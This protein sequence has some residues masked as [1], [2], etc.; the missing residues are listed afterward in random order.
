MEKLGEAAKIYV[1]MQVIAS[2]VAIPFMLYIF[3]KIMK[4]MRKF[5][6]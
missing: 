6:K 1:W 2:V 4:E 3:W 5:K